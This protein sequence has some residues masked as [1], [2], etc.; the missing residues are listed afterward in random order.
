MGKLTEISAEFCINA[1]DGRK[2]LSKTEL[3]KME[4]EFSFSLEENEII[5]FSLFLNCFYPAGIDN[6]A[7][8]IFKATFL[9]KWDS[10]DDFIENFMTKNGDMEK[11]MEF[12]PVLSGYIHYEK[13][14]R[15]YNS[16]GDFIFY[17]Y[18]E[19]FY[20]FDG[21]EYEKYEDLP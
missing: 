12:L 13:M 1:N 5:P 10:I 21:N 16:N 9:G 15:D 20:V 6:L 17:Y 19:S 7:Y 8:E 14:A 11:I 2:I 4:K 3:N 18:G